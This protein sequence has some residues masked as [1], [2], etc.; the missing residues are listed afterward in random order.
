MPEGARL[1]MH[2]EKL[3]LYIITL[4]EEARLQKVLDAA[5]CLA[6]EILV[7]DSGSTDR[8]GEIARSSGARFVVHE[9]ISIGHQVK[10]AEE[11]CSHRWVLRLDADEVIS[12]ELADEIRSVREKGTNDAYYMKIGNVIPGK[13]KPNPWVWHY[14]QARLY[15]RDSF[16]MTGLHGNDV[17]E[18]IRP[19]ATTGQLKGFVHHYTYISLFHLIDKHNIESGRLAERAA[20]QHKDYSPW[21]MVG[22]V[23]FNFLKMFFLD[24]YFL[25]GFW[26]FLFSVEYGLFRFLKFSKFYERTQ[27]EKHGSPF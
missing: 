21:R 3:S 11:Q 2:I 7:A 25:Y 24:R 10:W 23:T 4:N 16:S 22:A 14:N 26:G 5:S 13:T 12:P 27:F 15:N 8:T 9:F 19:G 1:S 6:D 18:K 17:V 20:M